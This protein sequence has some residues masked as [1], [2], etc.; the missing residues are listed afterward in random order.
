M[1]TAIVREGV[2]MILAGQDDFTV[3]GEA[4]TGREALEKAR[5]QRPDVV[6]MDISMPD[7]TGIRATEIIRKEMPSVQVLGLT[8]HEE[9]NY[10]FE[11]MKVGAAGY[12]LKRAAAG[13]CALRRPGTQVA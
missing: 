3:V 5:T 1:T 2:R 10:V 9:P 11:L 8:M 4:S 12:V 13:S 6:V 7:M